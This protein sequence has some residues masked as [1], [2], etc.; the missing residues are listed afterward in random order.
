MTPPLGHH[1][2]GPQSR[3]C[4]PLRWLTWQHISQHEPKFPSRKC[5][6]SLKTGTDNTEMICPLHWP[7]ATKPWNKRWKMDPQL[8]DICVG[9]SLII[10]GPTLPTLSRGIQGLQRSV[11]QA[12]TAGNETLIVHQILIKL[13]KNLEPPD[14]ET[15]SGVLVLINRSS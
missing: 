7:R 10:P 15:F 12:I 8:G 4:S 2:D 14:V 13:Y 1:E 3:C 5:W 11:L 9:G 6:H